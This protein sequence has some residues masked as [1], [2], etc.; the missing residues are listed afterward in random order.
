MF[1]LQHA[2]VAAHVALFAGLSAA[3][4]G[5]SFAAELAPTPANV[6]LSLYCL[7]CLAAFVFLAARSVED[8]GLGRACIAILAASVVFALAH[9]PVTPPWASTTVHVTSEVDGVW[10]VVFVVFLAYAMLPLK[11]AV[12]LGVGAALPVVHLIVSGVC[13]ENHLG[14]KWQ[15]VRRAEKMMIKLLYS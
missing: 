11:T 8:A 15:Q 4:A 7:S 1:K 14:L 5:A 9:L 6:Y 13:A 10:Q 2:S 3:L 12:A